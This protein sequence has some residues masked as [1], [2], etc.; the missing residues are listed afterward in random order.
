VQVVS[1]QFD[2][3]TCRSGVYLSVYCKEI[4]PSAL[5]KENQGLGHFAPPGDAPRTTLKAEQEG[6][7]GGSL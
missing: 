1:G 7:C 2:T 5:V 4:T 3:R 6:K